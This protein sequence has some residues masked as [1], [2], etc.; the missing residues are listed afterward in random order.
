[1][2]SQQ[3]KNLIWLAAGVAIGVTLTLAFAK[4]ERINTPSP[5]TLT[6]AIGNVPYSIVLE[7]H[8][9]SPALQA[10]SRTDDNFMDILSLNDLKQRKEGE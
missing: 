4:I 1:M 7:H 8:E 10:Y 2:L 6:Q 5:L 9:N 3:H